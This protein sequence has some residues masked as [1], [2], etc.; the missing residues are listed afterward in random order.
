MGLLAVAAPLLLILYL[1]YASLA[2]LRRTIPVANKAMMRKYLLSLAGEV[3][4]FYR[5]GAEQTLSIPPG[6]FDRTRIQ[7]KSYDVA[8]YFE[9][10]RSRIAKRLFLG[11]TGETDIG[12][13]FS[14]VL[15]YD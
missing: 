14:M 2:E 10:R 15:F 8:A 13:D 11:Y 6:I 7:T 4:D 12:K 5:D 3:E 9:K 1:Q